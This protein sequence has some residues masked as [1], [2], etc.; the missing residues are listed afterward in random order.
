MGMRGCVFFLLEVEEL[1]FLLGIVGGFLFLYYP[2]SSLFWM[3]DVVD[4]HCTG[5]RER[6]G[7][8]SAGFAVVCWHI[9]VQTCSHF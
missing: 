5:T 1:D 6:D 8:D 3:L 9:S 7:E 2:S 4:T